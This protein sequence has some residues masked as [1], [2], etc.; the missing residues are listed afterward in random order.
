MYNI[1][2]LLLFYRKCMYKCIHRL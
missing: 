2:L 1:S